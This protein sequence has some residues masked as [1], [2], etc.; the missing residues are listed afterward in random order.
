M[1]ATTHTGG[2]S[3]IK[4]FIEEKLGEDVASASM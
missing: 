2:T 4:K 1:G 3:E